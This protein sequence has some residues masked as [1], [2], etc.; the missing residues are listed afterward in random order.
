VSVQSVDTSSPVG[1]LVFIYIGLGG[2]PVALPVQ[3]VNGPI[4]GITFEPPPGFSV[5]DN[6][7]ALGTC[8]L[9]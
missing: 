5:V 3:P 2:Q 8:P 7:C 4:Q 9:G 6:G 1:T